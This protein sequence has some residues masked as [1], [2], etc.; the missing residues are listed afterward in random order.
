ME[1][2]NFFDKFTFE[3]LYERVRKRPGVFFGSVGL[4]G[5]HNAIL[6]LIYH[7]VESGRGEM[8]VALTGGDIRINHDG[9]ELEA[10]PEIDIVK[11]VCE[12]FRYKNNEFQFKFDKQIFEI[13]EPNTDALFDRLREL[14]VLN[15]GM[16]I[17]FNGYSFCYENGLLDYYQYQKTK[18]GFYWLD[19]DK[20]ISFR[21]KDGDMELDVVCIAVSTIEPCIFSFV[22]NCVTE[23]N[24]THVDGFIKGLR[25]ELRKNKDDSCEHMTGLKKS[26]IGLVIHVR[27]PRPQYAGGTKRRL[28]SQEIYQFVMNATRENLAHIF[29]ESLDKA[30]QFVQCWRCRLQA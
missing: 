25:S 20:P 6:H 9:E 4:A 15:K 19:N 2:K 11:A 24:G 26:D 17:S 13:T 1:E 21:A 12:T 8:S 27:S 23:E 16:K 29:A 7:C 18:A 30:H 22:N 5:L 3:E 14:A 10:H 28:S